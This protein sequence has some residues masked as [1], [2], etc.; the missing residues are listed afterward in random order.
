MRPETVAQLSDLFARVGRGVASFVGDLC[1]VLSEE[2]QAK[3][4]A[5]A[6]PL[7]TAHDV[8][9]RLQTNEQAVYRLAREGELPA[10]QTGQR[11]KRWTEN[12]VNDFIRRNG[13]TE[14]SEQSQTKALRLLAG[15][16]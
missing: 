8:A 13:V 15:K 3:N 7:L 11:A 4:A 9:A 14:Q 12:A 5:P 10:V 16:R 1:A 6:P 2:S